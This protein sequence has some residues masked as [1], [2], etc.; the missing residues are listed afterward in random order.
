MAFARSVACVA[1]ANLW[2]IFDGK[3]LEGG[4]DHKIHGEMMISIFIYS[5]MFSRILCVFWRF[6]ERLQEFDAI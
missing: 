4:F 1:K 5:I 2:Q 6:S 3:R